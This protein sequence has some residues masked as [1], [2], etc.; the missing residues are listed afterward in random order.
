MELLLDDLAD[1][2]QSMSFTSIAVSTT[3]NI[4]RSASFGFEATLVASSNPLDSTTTKPHA[5]S[6]DSY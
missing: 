2:L 1:D 5:P 6:F 4:T 3:T